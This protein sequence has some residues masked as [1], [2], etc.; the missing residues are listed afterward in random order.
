MNNNLLRSPFSHR[1]NSTQQLIIAA[2]L[3]AVALFLPFLTGQ[4]QSIGSMLLPMHFP[5]F[6]AAYLLGPIW[7][8]IIGA[9]SPL[10]RTL[11]F[12]MPPMPMTAVMA[13][14]MGAYTLVAGL[15]NNILLRNKP[16]MDTVPRVLISLIS[17]MI[18]GRVVYAL[19]F[20]AIMGN[21]LSFQ[22]FFAS[23]VTGA[24][25]GI[26]LQIILVPIIVQAIERSQGIKRTV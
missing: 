26:V 20:G 3:L 14:E 10:L 23:T 5:A 24:W 9:L 4:I 18:I 21:T 19:A 2:V 12:S 22:V 17:G 16:Q 7:G 13:F 1:W 11:I 25:P 6:L 8:L 15:I